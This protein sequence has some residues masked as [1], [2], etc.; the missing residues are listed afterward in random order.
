MFAKKTL[1]NVCARE[2][3]LIRE[4]V[5]LVA[6]LHFV[7]LRPVLLRRHVVLVLL[8]LLHGVTEL[9]ESRGRANQLVVGQSSLWGKNI[10]DVST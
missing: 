5:L 3:Y 7:L 8:D 2:F 9:L 10:T 4:D 1:C 6:L